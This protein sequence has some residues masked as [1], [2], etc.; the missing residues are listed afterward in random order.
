MNIFSIDY[1]KEKWAHAGFQ[2]YFQNTGWMFASKILSMG[3][4]FL[5]TIYIARNLGPTNYGQL[6]YALSFVGIFSFLASLGIDNILYRDLISY[7][8]KRKEL[9]GSAFIVKIIAG[10]FTA[11]LISVVVISSSGSNDI[12]KILIIIISGTF[13][14]NPF[15]IIGLEFQARVK[16]K[17][18]SITAFI[19][20]IILNALKVIAIFSGKGV[21][22]L[23]MILLLEPILYTI[24][25]WFI[26]EKHTGEKITSWIFDKKIAFDLM[27]DSWPLMFSSVFAVIYSEIDQVLIKNMINTY[28]V[29]IYDSAV[30]V[31]EVF[32]FIPNIIIASLFP[33][34][35][36]AKITS[37][38]LYQKRLQKISL[39]LVCL[40]GLI[41]ISLTLF[42]PFIIKILYGDAFVGSVV[43]LKIYTWSL[44]GTFLG[45]LIANYLIAENYRKISFFVNLIP[46]I[47]NVLFDIIWIPKYGIIGPAYATLIAYSLSPLIL[48]FF[49]NTRKDLLKM[50][51]TT[52]S[53][54]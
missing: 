54:T 16:S 29:G 12:S 21:L 20:T 30:R 53:H 47:V 9:L 25:Y 37:R 17:Y 10:I 48:L 51:R 52:K 14:F 33:A 46:M 27:R 23:A 45:A 7:P 42:A 11:I 35:I 8:E 28:S 4:S 19:V 24:F 44:I 39:L 15:Q 31:T 5:A 38:E 1:I 49:T 2:K 36:N 18:L 26:Y 3:V 34:I 32:Y 40:A 22:Y 6:S 41:S 50:F 13:I 43:I